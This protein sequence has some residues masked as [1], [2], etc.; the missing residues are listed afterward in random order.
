MTASRDF[1]TIHRMLGPAGRHGG[2]SLPGRC[3]S[4]GGGRHPGGPPRMSPYA[5]LTE[6]AANGHAQTAK[7]AI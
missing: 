2:I 1:A 7:D 5:G 3:S 4:D 6:S